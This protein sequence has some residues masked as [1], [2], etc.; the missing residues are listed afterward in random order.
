[1]LHSFVCF[2]AI[3]SCHSLFQ[4]SFLM[5]F[6]ERIHSNETVSFRH[7]FVVKW[8]WNK[9]YLSFLCGI[10]TGASIRENSIKAQ[11]A[12]RLICDFFEKLF[13][14][15]ANVCN[16]VLKRHFFYTKSFISNNQLRLFRNL[17]VINNSTCYSNLFVLRYY[18]GLSKWLDIALSQAIEAVFLNG[19]SAPLLINAVVLY[20]PPYKLNL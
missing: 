9:K 7:Y 5:L 1:M 8:S 17:N 19:K 18:N 4:W 12:L 15:K 3:F 16:H 11:K 13:L 6:I 2:F 10:Q 14:L 20:Q